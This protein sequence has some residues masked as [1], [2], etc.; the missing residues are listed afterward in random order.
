MHIWTIP[1]IVYTMYTINLAQ[2]D[3]ACQCLHTTNR[4]R[5]PSCLIYC[6]IIRNNRIRFNCFSLPLFMVLLHHYFSY[7]VYYM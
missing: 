4:A 6:V 1:G 5:N 2:S 7:I 3:T